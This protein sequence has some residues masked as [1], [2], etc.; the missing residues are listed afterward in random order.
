MSRGREGSDFDKKMLLSSSH[1]KLGID[2]LATLVHFHVFWMKSSQNL[3]KSWLEIRGILTLMESVPCQ[4]PSSCFMPSHS[5]L[6]TI[7]QSCIS[8]PCFH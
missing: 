3:L 7:Y 8:G 2:G 1:A 5:I 4:P 6:T